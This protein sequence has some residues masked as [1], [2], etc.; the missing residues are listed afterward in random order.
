HEGELIAAGEAAL[1]ERDDEIRRLRAQLDRPTSLDGIPEWV[2]TWLGEGLVF[3]PRAEKEIAAA[4]PSEV[5]LPLLC[6]A[7]EFLANDYREQLLGRIGS[8]ECR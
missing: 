2:R 4:D 1:A 7:L 5:R 3:H 6:D 8:E